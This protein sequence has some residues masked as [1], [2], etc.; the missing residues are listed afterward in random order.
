MLLR[1]IGE[2]F[3]PNHNLTIG[4]EFG[5]KIIEED[6][7]RIKLQIWDTAS[8]EPFIAITIAYYKNAA[9]VIILYNIT[10]F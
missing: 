6:G 3:V 7:K 1:F 4:V 5:S 8:Q 2:S 10:I 9:G